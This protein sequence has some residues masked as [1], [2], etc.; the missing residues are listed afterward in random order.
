[1]DGLSYEL[2]DDLGL[3]CIESLSDTLPTETL[4]TSPSQTKKKINRF[5]GNRWFLTFHKTPST[6]AGLGEFDDALPPTEWAIIAE[7]N[8]GWNPTLHVA[9]KFQ[10][11]ISTR[12]MNYFDRVTGKHGNYNR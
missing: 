10:E 11:P 5:R 4:T 8:K 7:E 2:Y 3:H 6:P 9:L 12:D 1:M